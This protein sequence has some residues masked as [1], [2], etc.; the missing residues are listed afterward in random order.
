MGIGWIW[1]KMSALACLVLLSSCST[2][3][4]DLPLCTSQ[5]TFY[6]DYNMKYVDA[7]PVAV[8]K[9]DVYVFDSKDRFVTVFSEERNAFGENFQIPLSLP[10]G[11]YH[12]ITWAGR[13]ERSYDFQKDLIPGYST[14]D[15]LWVRMR[16]GI[17]GSQNTELDALWHGD[18]WVEISPERNQT[19]SIGLTKDT[20]R[21]RIVVQ[22]PNGWDGEDLQFCI[23]DQNGFLDS[24]NDLLPDSQVFYRPYFQQLAEVD[25]EMN[26]LAD[27]ESDNASHRTK[28]KAAVAELNTLRLTEN[29]HPR[30]QISYPDGTSIVNID[31]IQ[32][33]L[34]TKMEGH[35]MGAQEY[36]DRQDE[37]ALVF[38]LAQDASG[39]YVVMKIQVN[40]WTLRPQNGDF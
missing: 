23:T 14:S 19:V 9:L 33:L 16:R 35:D 30:L 39:K 6:Y 11:R 21:F 29:S 40:G 3:T 5:L 8:K 31:L 32:Y 28:L 13:Y 20:N 2:I 34:L 36:M 38:F 15:D 37:F 12:F 25:G 17:D 24:N 18:S 4:E 10:E 22:G 27:S 7:F 1:A 26:A